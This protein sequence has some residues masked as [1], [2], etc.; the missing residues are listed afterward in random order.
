MCEK[1]RGG[2]DCRVTALWGLSWLSDRGK[3]SCIGFNRSLCY[4]YGSNCVRTMKNKACL[5][6]SAVTLVS[7]LW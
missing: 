3:L 2:G 4:I 6:A 1:G 7:T 5:G